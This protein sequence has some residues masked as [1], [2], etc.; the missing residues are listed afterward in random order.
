LDF[1]SIDFETAN[2]NRSSACALGIVIVKGGMIK[3]EHYFLI[4]PEEDFDDYCI[5]IHGITPSLVKGKPT[6]KLLWESIEPYFSENLI[7]AHN[8]SFD[9]SV[10]RYSLNKANIPFPALK[11]FC[12]YILSK[13]LLTG[14]SSYRLDVV[15]EHFGI[16]FKHHNALED[17]RTAALIMLKYLESLSHTNLETAA[18]SLGFNHGELSHNGYKPFGTAASYGEKIRSKD[19]VTG[20]SEFNE[21]H[22]LFGKSIAFTGTL[23]SMSRQSAMQNV[24]DVGGI[25]ADSVNKQVNFLIVGFRDF[26]L[27]SNGEKS[28]KLKKAEQYITSG[29]DL[30][31]ISEDDFLRMI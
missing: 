27:Y 10:F 12:T 28:T 20:N 15:A 6:F 4:D 2:N 3:D 1:V 29:Q 26:T 21:S 14:L 13:K 19:I 31:I 11:Y 17:A 7:V 24:V 25:C 22:P 23:S 5:Q 9:M 30:E 16:A 18:T 8:A